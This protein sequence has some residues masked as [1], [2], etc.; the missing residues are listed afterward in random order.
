MSKEALIKRINTLENTIEKALKNKSDTFLVEFPWAGN[1]GQWEWFYDK[2]LVVFNDKKATQLGYDPDKIGEVGYQ[3]F[4]NK[5]HP[6]DYERTMDN[7]RQHLKGETEAYEVEYRIQHKDG[8]YLWYYDRGVVTQRDDSGKPVLLQGIVFDITESKKV[9]E[10]LRQLSEED[11]LTQTYNRR[12]LYNVLNRLKGKYQKSGT[13]FSVIMLDI[14]HF[15]QVNDKY[16]HVTGDKV[17]KEMAKYIRNNKRDQDT[18]FRYGGEE[19]I[20]TLQNTKLSQAKKIAQRFHQ[21]IND[22]E[23]EDVGHITV[24]MGVVQ[25]HSKESSDD[26]INRVDKLLYDAKEAGRDQI[27]SE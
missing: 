9:E 10:K 25:Y 26:L 4:T 17:L 19:F 15:K 12:E 14:D 22:L 23:F 1:L 13:V 3:F 8:H 20:I 24:S 2:N 6:D 11:E 5:L 18:V 21:G 27:K 7:M 16:G